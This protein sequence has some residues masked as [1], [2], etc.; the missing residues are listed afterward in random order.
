MF[1]S[2]ET[3]CKPQLVLVLI[4]RCLTQEQTTSQDDAAKKEIAKRL[5]LTV[6]AHQ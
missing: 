4:V 5:A 1:V 2:L 3:I 6:S